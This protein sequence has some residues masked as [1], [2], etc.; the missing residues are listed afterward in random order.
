MRPLL[1]QVDIAS[2][3]LT[4]WFDE[5]VENEHYGACRGTGVLRRDGDEWRIAQ[6]N[7]T[8]PVPTSSPRSSWRRSVGMRAGKNQDHAA[9][10]PQG[11]VQRRRSEDHRRGPRG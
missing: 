6:Y 3:G 1:V 4:A 11:P 7:L 8:I 10:A 9:A 2:D 5:T